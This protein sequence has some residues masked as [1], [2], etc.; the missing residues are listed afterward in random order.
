M[1][2]FDYGALL[3]GLG[4]FLLGMQQLEA[5]LKGLLGRSVKLFIRRHTNSPLKGIAVGAATTAVLQSSSLVTLMLLAFVGAGILSLGN[6]IGVVLGANLGTTVTGWLVTALGFKLDLEAAAFPL[7]GIGALG[8]LFFRDTGR[9]TATAR[10][11]LALGFLLFGLALMKGGAEEFAA[12]VDVAFLRGFGIVLFAIAGFVL[13]AF[14]RSSSAAMLVN[15]SALAAGTI[16]L[17]QAA[18][19]AVGADLG[20]TITVLIGALH[21]YAGK[22]RV[23]MAHFLFNLIT[24]V[25]ALVMLYPLL[26]VI[27][28]VTADPLFALVA[29]HSAFNAIGILV[30]LP[31]V[32]RFAAFLEARFGNR[33]ENVAR[34]I[35]QMPLGV[36]D[37]AIVALEREA[38][39][40]VYRVLLLNRTTLGVPGAWMTAIPFRPE[41]FDYA[42]RPELQYEAVKELEGEML[43]FINVLQEQTLAADESARLAQLQL[44]VRHAVQAAKSVKD[45]RHNLD[46]FAGS[47]K[48]ALH[49]RFERMREESLDFHA[50]VDALWKLDRPDSRFAELAAMA[51]QNRLAHERR[52]HEIYRDA[53]KDGLEDVEVSTLLNVNRELFSSNKSLVVALKD[54]LLPAAA[55]EE[56]AAL[57]GMA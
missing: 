2:G 45:V 42:M 24:G 36:P 1:S 47:V 4:F 38:A 43:A 57:P 30:F 5:S 26:R 53:R 16:T 37:A 56:L 50:R 14:I 21:G 25:V 34:F 19:F 41:H 11:L 35:G 54:L 49:A 51:D 46:D 40:L 27:A 10:F 15:L 9:F 39:H 18:A 23:A 29:F 32:R 20:T 33:D 17:P 8:S 13:S 6:A 3:A 55:A 7:I 44:A 31:F 28:L 12:S 22:R 48:D 52:S